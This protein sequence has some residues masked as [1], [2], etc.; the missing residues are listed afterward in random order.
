MYTYVP[1]YVP[2]HQTRYTEHNHTQPH[3]LSPTTCALVIKV[4]EATRLRM[5]VKRALRDAH[6]KCTDPKALAEYMKK[7]LTPTH[8]HV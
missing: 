4:R 8:M 5:V 2:M 1:L 6:D 3:P 7:E